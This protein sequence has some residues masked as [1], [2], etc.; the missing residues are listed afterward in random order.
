MKSQVGHRVDL[1]TAFVSAARCYWLS[2]FPRVQ[3][4]LRY[5]R[6]RA[7]EIPDPHLRRLALETHNAK[8][9]NVE[10]AAAFATLAPT[11]YRQ[12]TIKALVTF[13]GVYD[14]ADTIAEQPQNDPV[15]NGRLLHQ[16]LLIALGRPARHLNYYAHSKSSDDGGY[17]NALTDACGAAFNELPSGPLVREGIRRAARRIVIYQSLNHSGSSSHAALARWAES[18]TSP[19]NWLRW[20]E[21]SAACASSLTALALFSAAADP[22]LTADDVV[23]IERAYHPW[24]GALHTLLDSLVDWTEDEIAGQ[25]SLLDHYDSI[26]ELTERM[27]ILV[28]RSR[29]ATMALPHARRHT[30]LLAG[31]VGQYLAAPEV[32]SPRTRYVANGLLEAMDDL[33]G[34]TLRVMQV[35]R[36]V[37]R[38]PTGW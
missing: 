11:A 8:W 3:R 24:I 25:P 4:E 29:D 1:A 10:G 5:W 26:A 27:K 36:G 21:T 16:P 2:V 14:Y 15:E 23:A 20:W 6:T 9:C 22:A 30:V 32:G 17:L 19:T 13:Q 34:P 37:R 33:M 12:T 28:Q 18:E 38:L 7:R 31:M 35:R